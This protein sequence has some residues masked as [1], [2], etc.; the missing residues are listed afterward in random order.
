MPLPSR[1][2]RSI[3]RPAVS[4]TARSV[5]GPTPAPSKVSAIESIV[6]VLPFSASAMARFTA[7]ADQEHR[8]SWWVTRELNSVSSRS[9]ARSRGQRMA[10]GGHRIT[11]PFPAGWPPSRSQT[12]RAASDGSMP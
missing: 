1:R 2:R 3:E 5:C 7:Y 6:A 11:A 4:R 8:G 9:F 12:I 10:T